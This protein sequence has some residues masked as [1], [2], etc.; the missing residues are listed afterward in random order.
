MRVKSMSV[1]ADTQA[2][3][4]LSVLSGDSELGPTCLIGGADA[5]ARLAIHVHHFASSLVASL[6]DK[7]PATRWLIGD[8]NFSTAAIAFV[9]AHPPRAPCV[10]EYAGDFPQ[11]LARFGPMSVLPYLKNFARLEW[12]LGRVS[13]AVDVAPLTWRDVVAIGSGALINARISL[14]TGLAYVRSDYGIDALMDL[15]LKDEAPESFTLPPCDA[16]IEVRGARG[17]MSMNR[18]NAGEFDFR[19]ALEAGISVGDA[20]ELGLTADADF[21]VGHAL[22]NLVGNRLVVSIHSGRESEQ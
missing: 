12:A 10:A 19:R 1:L 14:Q 17:L 5:H 2:A 4:A 9:R 18:L 21:D 7:F 16:A 3:V 11:F 20:A 13:I 6:R 8:E 15:Y 22:R